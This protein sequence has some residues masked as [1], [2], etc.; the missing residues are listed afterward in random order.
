MCNPWPSQPSST[1]GTVTITVTA[2]DRQGPFELD[3]V[4]GQGR[5]VVAKDVRI[6]A[7]DR[8]STRI[9]MPSTRAVLQLVVPGVGRVPV[10]SLILDNSAQAT[11]R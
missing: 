7:G 8:Y 3:L 2:G 5:T 6:A 9:A 1:S 11:T 4:T 10:R